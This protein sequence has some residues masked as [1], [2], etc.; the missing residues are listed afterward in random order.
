[1]M[2]TLR[3]LR[4][5]LLA[6][7]VSNLGCA[8]A[9]HGRPSGP[10][11]SH[12]RQGW[13]L[14]RDGKSDAA[15]ASF[16]RALAADPLDARA[17]FGAAN[18]AF[19]HG[20]PSAALRYALTLL[21]S[22]SQGRD[23]RAMAL[24]PAVLARLSRLLAEIPDRR[25]AENRIVALAPDPLPW[26]A[27]YLLALT[28]IDIARKRADE[29]LLAKAVARA[30]CARSMQLVGSWGRL[31]S[32]DLEGEA[33]V[34]EAKV[35]GLVQ[36]GCQFQLNAADN[37]SGV[38]I[39]RAEI[40]SARGH[41]DL[42]LDYGGPARLRVDKGPWRQH[43]DSPDVVGPRWSAE[44]IDT[45]AGKHTVEI[46]IGAYGSSAD[47]ALLAIPV[48]QSNPVTAETFSSSD[49][50][51]LDL[52][53]ALVA[54][55]SGEVDLLLTHIE[56]LSVLPRFALGLAA[57]A[58]L[59]EMD[60]TRPADIM[61][62][63]ART[64]WQQAVAIDPG[65][66]RVW[67]DLS[68]LDLQN[69]QSREATEKAE[70]AMQAA[71]VWWPAHLA[72]ATALR[73]QGLEQPADVALAR[74]LQL[75][76]GG[77]GACDMLEE[78]FHRAEARDDVRAATRLVDLLGRCDAQDG[79]A[80]FFAQRRGDL[81]K[82][83]LLLRRALPTSAEPLWLRSEIADL[84]LAQGHL[85]P[86]RDELSALVQ[87]AP[88]DTRLRIRL[89]DIQTAL[90]KPEQA[91]A[92]LAAAVHFFPG[93]SDVRRAARLAGLALPLDDFRLD[94]EQVMRDYLASGRSYQAPAV[95]VLDRAVERVYAD[96]TRL[97]LTHSITQVLSKDAIAAVGEV[98]VPEG[99]EVLIL[100][101][102]K[103]DGTSR[104]AEE[105]A[106]KSTISAPELGV[107]DFV[108]SETLEVKEPSLAFAPGFAG[109]R[110]FFQ[111]FEA[112]LDRSEYLLVA[113]A[114]MPLDVDRRADAP[115]PSTTL[116]RD[117]T[118][119]LTFVV[120]GNPQ[121]FPERSAVPALEWIPS[122]RVSSSV[123]PDGWSRFVAN[124]GKGLSRGSPEVRKVAAD[125]A[126]QVGSDR[127]RLPEAI[128]AWVRETI[129]PEN[130]FGA[131]AT[132]TLA[133]HRG[134]RAWLILALA[135]SLGVEADVVLARSLL[136]AEADV[137][138]TAAEQD[139]FRELLVRFPSAAG[140][141]FV[142]PQIRRAPFD[143]LLPGF[144][145]APA[146]VVGTQ[147]RV[148]AVSGV[149]DSRS[150]T[151][152]ARLESDGGAKVA[153]TE[154]LSGWPS[155]EWTE[156]L[157]RAGKDRNKLRQD[158][159]Q[160][161]LGQQFPG[162][163]LDK[164]SI[165]PGEGGA[166]TRVSYTFR[167]AR[168]AGRQEGMLHLRPAFFQAQPGRRFGTEP[169][170][171]TTLML[172]YDIPLDLDAEIALPS[173]AKVMDV[174]QGGDVRAGGARFFEKRQVYD[175]GDGLVT[176]SLRRQSR[177]P[178][179]RVT[180]GDYQNLATKLR[181]VDPVEQ[182]EIRIAVPAK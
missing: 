59:G 181:A 58:R 152:R 179:M 178:I 72:V 12:G 171:K 22:A 96:G 43:G 68:K 122:V 39:L 91:R 142:D 55:L 42:V 133:R 93:R 158:F 26:K 87:L 117:G 89:A 143:Y 114:A 37:R 56:R 97:V 132:M 138:A 148:T 127:H 1:M 9:M 33:M 20:D 54:N 150:V 41:F 85:Q 136:K 74:G 52:A 102:R 155:V 23:A 27:Q 24:S 10:A 124:R 71:P 145:G 44:R 119:V 95:V 109:E 70:R 139:D 29:A 100:R 141:R 153:V 157:D 11:E 66:A 115:Q 126:K 180:P 111:S 113:P 92:T 47:L 168:M 151:L 176:V 45:S 106:G 40:E 99:A 67:L 163:Q 175:A 19:E 84:L 81:G 156:M 5:G 76:D 75:I 121:A 65:M 6:L 35:R 36:A 32:L 134:H 131:A 48:A 162:A 118:R 165:E 86:A 167:S 64:L 8:Q 7:L 80:R 30:G 3:T 170:R 31:P 166:G 50:A 146:V 172:G 177:L 135:R 161:W 4:A 18:L 147:K 73:G 125:I 57:A 108:E 88:R 14:L 144:D 53:G 16:A 79:N 112:P 2:A 34:P 128:V 164:L 17:L 120:H 103:A 104:E 13:L 62:D 154:Q 174:G 105:I 140:D 101:T 60:P 46:R 78:A 116:P 130:E 82:A 182:G 90:G 63:R 21:E 129:E 169:Q 38:R 28:V 107:G 149:K 123:P 94:G 173:G 159:E 15:A 61:R 110:F 77:L 98:H 49:A 25:P 160:H 137:P 83:L 51:M 69:D